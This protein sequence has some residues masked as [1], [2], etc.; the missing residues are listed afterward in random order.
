MNDTENQITY[1]DTAQVEKLYYSVFK[2]AKHFLDQ[3]KRFTIDQL[4]LH[5]DPTYD[6]VANLANNL[7]SIITSLA[8]S[9]GW[10]EERIAL[11]ARQAAL[12]MEQMALA[13]SKKDAESLSD[14]AQKLEKMDFI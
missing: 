14:A 1:V 7:A 6:E 9:G 13:I 5:N 8:S 4:H 12:F 2:V 11:N 10:D 3:S